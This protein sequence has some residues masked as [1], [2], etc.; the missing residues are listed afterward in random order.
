MTAVICMCTPA[1]DRIIASFSRHASYCTLGPNIFKPKRLFA[2]H[3]NESRRTRAA[4]EA[5]WTRCTTQPG[6]IKHKNQFVV[7]YGGISQCAWALCGVLGATSSLRLSV[8]HKG[9]RET[10]ATLTNRLRGANF[11]CQQPR[12]LSL[13]LKRIGSAFPTV[14]HSLDWT[15]QQRRWPGGGACSLVLSLSLFPRSD[16]QRCLSSRLWVCLRFLPTGNFSP[17][18]T[19]YI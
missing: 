6:H 10:N 7:P 18:A 12:L 1:C 5:M 2:G 16:A 4:A 8:R 11:P 15:S 9:G 13:P 19:C 14:S 3:H 17:A